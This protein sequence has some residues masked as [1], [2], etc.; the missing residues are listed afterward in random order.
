MTI[1]NELNELAE[2]MTGVNPKATTDKQALDYIADYYAGK[3]LKPITNSQ[4]IK[5]IKDYYTN[6]QGDLKITAGTSGKPGFAILFSSFPSVTIEGASADYL[7]KGYSFGDIPKINGSK[8]V[9]TA[10]YMFDNCQSSSVDLS[11]FDTT[12]VTNMAYMFRGSKFTSLDLSNFY[13]SKVTNMTYMFQGNSSI[14]TSLDLSNFD[15]KNV[16]N[17]ASMFG[18]VT[19]VAILDIS[20]FDFSNIESYTEIF[21]K[22]GTL[23][24]ASN[25]AYADG[26]PYVYV[27]DA[28]A[29]NWILNLSSSDRPVAWTTNN[30]IIKSN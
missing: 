9:T 26:I 30:V 7:F 1:V 22:T 16:T 29:Q 21:Y 20:N 6:Q 2:K 24:L 28:T 23:S 15:T 8:D 13:T 19:R 4:A 3:D 11:N 10:R 12:N 18:N 5:N 14:L 27:K 25:G 17:M